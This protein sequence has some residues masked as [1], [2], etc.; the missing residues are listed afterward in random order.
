MATLAAYAPD[1]S[2]V[3]LISALNASVAATGLS[4]AVQGAAPS[5]IA[6]AQG[7]AFTV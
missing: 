5:A 7:S 2:E 6:L 4:T 3:R 1:A